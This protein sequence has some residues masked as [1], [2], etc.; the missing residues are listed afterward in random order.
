MG[1]WAGQGAHDGGREGGVEVLWM[2]VQW[3]EMERKGELGGILS[4]IM[5]IIMRANN[6][7]CQMFVQ[8]HTPLRR[9]L[10]WHIVNVALK[11]SAVNK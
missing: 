5:T 1:V 3:S 4:S 10:L 8:G 7:L 11:C 2:G 9:T 6:P